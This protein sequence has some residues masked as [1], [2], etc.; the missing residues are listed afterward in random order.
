MA[1][2]VNS[3][4]RSLTKIL[5]SICRERR[6]ETLDKVSE[7]DFLLKQKAFNVTVVY[8]LDIIQI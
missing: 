6:R 7:G 3:S 4:A 2:K 1:S 5:E 8:L